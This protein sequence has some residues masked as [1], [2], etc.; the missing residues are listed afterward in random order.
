MLPVKVILRDVN[1]NQYFTVDF[2][3][4]SELVQFHLLVYP[5]FNT[6]ITSIM[7]TNGRATNGAVA[8]PTMRKVLIFRKWAQ[9]FLLYQPLSLTQ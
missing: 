4:L 7:N 1:L 6:A 5:P 2:K 8:E 3:F 9:L